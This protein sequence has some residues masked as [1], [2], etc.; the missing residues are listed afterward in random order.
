MPLKTM[1][2][3][4]RLWELSDG[5]QQLE[6]AIANIQEDETLSDEEL[7]NQLQQTFD[8]WLQAGESF[9]LKAEQ[10]AAYIRH[11]E[12]LAEA[13][14]TEAKRIQALAKQAENGATRLRKYLVAQM[15]RS[16]VKK[17]DGTTVKIGLRKKQP[18]ILINVPP[19]ELPAEYLNVTYKANLTEIRKLLK[20]DSDIGWASLSES[21]EYSVTIR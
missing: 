13:R 3:S 16:D 18:Q 8:E 14:K 10:V 1:T 17:I 19:E 11:Q 7:E 15:I 9:K 4:T 21:H 20:S 12:A 2:E 6:N 5:I